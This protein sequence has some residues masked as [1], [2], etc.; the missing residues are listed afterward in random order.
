VV[1]E[2]K[3]REAGLDAVTQ[4]ARY[5]EEVSKRRDR[6]TRGILCA[7]KITPNALRMLERDGLEFFKLDYEIGNPSAK[8]TG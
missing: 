8:I 3:R 4:L 5:V 7:P 1:I 2:L 6:A